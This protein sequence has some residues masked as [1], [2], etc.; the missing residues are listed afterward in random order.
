VPMPLWCPGSCEPD[1][2]VGSP[3]AARLLTVA[4]CRQQG[5]RLLKFL[6]AAGDAALQGTVAPSLLPRQRGGLTLTEYQDA[7]GLWITACAQS[8]DRP[9]INVEGWRPNS[10]M[11]VAGLQPTGPMRSI[12]RNR[13]DPCRRP[14]RELARDGGLAAAGAPP[15]TN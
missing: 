1:G 3:F 13:V 10:A 12:R 5:R 14:W 2:A 4:T 7:I 11:Q 8:D 15:A 9:D 6:V